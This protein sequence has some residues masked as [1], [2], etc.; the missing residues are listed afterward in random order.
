M[1]ELKFVWALLKEGGQIAPLATLVVLLIIWRNDLKHVAN[2][3][4]EV[5]RGFLKHLEWHAGNPH[6]R[7][8]PFEGP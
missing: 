7:I 5:K 1:E 8:P 6:P 3:L 2:D 4:A